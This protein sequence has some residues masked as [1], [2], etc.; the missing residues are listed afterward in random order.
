M[1]TFSVYTFA[2]WALSQGIRIETVSKML[3]HTNVVTTQIYA[4][5]LQQEVSNA[6]DLLEEKVK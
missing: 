4:K 2:T 5:I 3:A 6:Y 1:I